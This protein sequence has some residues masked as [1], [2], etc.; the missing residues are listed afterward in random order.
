MGVECLGEYFKESSLV[1]SF[2][3]GRSFREE[4]AAPWTA[5]SSVRAGRGG[6]SRQHPG[7]RQRGALRAER[8][9]HQLMLYVGWLPS[10]IRR[11][12][13]GAPALALRGRG[14]TR[15]GKGPG[16]SRRQVPAGLP[17]SRS[18]GCSTRLLRRERGGRGGH[19]ARTTA[20]THQPSRRPHAPGAAQLVPDTWG[21]LDSRQTN[22]C[23][24]AEAKRLG[25]ATFRRALAKR[26]SPQPPRTSDLPPACSPAPAPP[27]HRLPRMQEIGPFHSRSPETLPLARGHKPRE[28]LP[29]QW[30]PCVLLSAPFLH[31][32]EP[33]S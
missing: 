14:P 13:V 11:V 27:P 4:A 20:L 21:T 31:T 2:H 19:A 17:P 26:R 6:D 33:A 9:P 12:R 18:C 32:T 10:L 24:S 15:G 16:P 25:S 5:A 8:R 22:C 28:W 1:N 29:A 7:Q 3:E 23:V 30:P